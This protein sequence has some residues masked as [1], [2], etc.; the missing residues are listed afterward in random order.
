VDCHSH[1][2]KFESRLPRG[3]SCCGKPRYI[4]EQ[5][6]KRLFL[7]WQNAVPVLERDLPQQSEIQY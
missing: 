3:C 4:W 5:F 7:L 1:A 6:A 2:F